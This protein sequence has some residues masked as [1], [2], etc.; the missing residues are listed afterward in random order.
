MQLSLSYH[1]SLS[2]K[3]IPC[4][5]GDVLKQEDKAPIAYRASESSPDV[6]ASRFEVLVDCGSLIRHQNSTW[7]SILGIAAAGASLP[8]LH[9]SQDVTLGLFPVS[10]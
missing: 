8:H 3:F 6:Y 4:M 5:V 10:A 9:G 2:G 1:F 7:N